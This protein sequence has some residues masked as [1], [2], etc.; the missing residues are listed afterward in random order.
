[1]HWTLNLIL[2]TRSA[3]KI[4]FQKQENKPFDYEQTNKQKWATRLRAATMLISFNLASVPPAYLQRAGD[5][6]PVDRAVRSFLFFFVVNVSCCHSFLHVCTCS[7]FRLSAIRNIFCVSCGTIRNILTAC[8]LNVTNFARAAKILNNCGPCCCCCCCGLLCLTTWESE[9]IF[10]KKRRR[11]RKES[12]PVTIWPPLLNWTRH[13][14]DRTKWST[15]NNWKQSVGFTFNLNPAGEGGV[16]P[17][18]NAWEEGLACLG[19]TV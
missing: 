10:G 5:L 14:S 19:M 17:Q 6:C 11:K 2:S 3:N 16:E 8:W 9:N 12:H 13:I 4:H 1:M 18:R 7:C 15:H